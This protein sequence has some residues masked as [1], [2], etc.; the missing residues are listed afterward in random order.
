MVGSWTINVNTSGMPQKIATAVGELGEKLIG[1]E[2]SPIAYLGSQIV[3]GTNH[4]VL[5]EQL[6]LTGKD[7]K[8]IVLLIF[9]EK[10][11]VVTLSNIERVI[12]AGGPFGGTAIDVKANIPEDAQSVFDQAMAGFVGSNVEPFALLGTK[13]VKGIDYLFAA[14]VTPVTPEAITKVAI[15]KVNLLEKSIKFMDILNA[16]LGYAFTW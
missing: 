14:T 12:E 15:V 16:P 5:A 9:N 2:Y 7:T 8:N 11:G 13:V 1:A 6:L 4:A 3:N 10:D